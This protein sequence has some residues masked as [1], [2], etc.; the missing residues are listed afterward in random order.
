M[1]QHRTFQLEER[2][3]DGERTVEASLS[4]ELPVFR[5]GLGNEILKHTA[6]AIDLSRA[7]LPLLT[8]H[9]AGDM[10]IGI[11]EN[12]RLV[13]RMLRGTLR[14][15][16]G[17]RASEL[18][19][20]V[21][22]GVLRNL[23][24]GYQ[25]LEGSSDGD[26]YIA[27]R[28]QPL[29]VSLVSIPADHTVGIGRSFDM[30]GTIQMDTNTQEPQPMTRSQ[31]RAAQVEVGNREQEILEIIETGRQ[32]KATELAAEFC[33]NGK[34]V[35]EFRAALLES[36]STKPS[37][38]DDSFGYGGWTSH[39]GHKRDF[40]Q[41]SMI[42]AINAATTND[43]THAGFEREVSQE[44]ERSSGKRAKGIYIPFEAMT[45][46]RVMT[47]GG[48]TTGS[49]LVPTIHT[50]FIDLL[51]NRAQVLAAGATVMGGLQGTVEIPKQTAASTAEWLA[52]DDALSGSDMN[53][54]AV[55]MT[56]KSV[57]A[58]MKWSRR[59]V[60]SS[61]PEVELLAR[62][63]LAQVIAL[64][65]DLAAIHGSGSG[66]QP[67]GIYSASGVNAVAMGGVPTYGK[68]IDMAAALGA[69]N[70][71]QGSLAHVTTPGMAAKMAQTLVAASAGSNMIWT[72]SLV[73]G[74]MAGFPAYATNQVSSVLGGGAEHGLIFGNWAEL[75]VG[76]WGGGV[77]ILVD[78]YTDADR[79]RV[80]IT[81]FCDMDIA[82]RHPESFCKATGAT[83]S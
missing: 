63:D 43:W 53:F 6:E 17:A 29:E 2:S 58:M 54:G 21:K 68:L 82:L 3:T 40:S 64:A 19:A 47:T 31:R 8:S 59:M 71:L 52:E 9:N 20:D 77:D 14:F 79:G 55:T 34:S 45:G 46:Q 30:K 42:R 76:I 15:S 37:R 35:A 66:N 1:I 75:I 44:I 4:S 22:A 24:I 11:I 16:E 70:A 83:V 26:N 74:R 78:P 18:W 38:T 65:I 50:G 27:T 60:H 36:M 13:G 48:A 49:A 28:W 72:G 39:Q 73:E 7:P 41:Y 56:P 69:D 12:I 23:S 81:A 51:R 57:G 61:V 5:Y 80:R 67:T 10:P 32:Y 25:I 62:N 33:R